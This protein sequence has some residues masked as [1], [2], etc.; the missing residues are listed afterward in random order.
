VGN[1]RLGARHKVVFVLAMGEQPTVKEEGHV[2]DGGFAIVGRSP[3]GFVSEFA[4]LVQVETRTSV[5]HFPQDV[6]EFEHEGLEE[7]D[8]RYPLVVGDL[9][10]LKTETVEE[11]F[12]NASNKKNQR[13]HSSGS[14]ACKGILKPRLK[15]M[16]LITCTLRW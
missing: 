5:Q 7:K 2:F 9:G 4:D 10:F 3:L 6:G 1:L 8:E 12:K 16:K 13:R 14:K 15:L 11:I